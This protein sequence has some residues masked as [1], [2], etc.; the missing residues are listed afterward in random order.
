MFIIDSNVCFIQIDNVVPSNILSAME[1]VDYDKSCA[2]YTFTTS[3]MK[4]FNTCVACVTDISCMFHII[5][6]AH[7]F[8][9]NY[10][11]SIPIYSVIRKYISSLK[12]NLW[13]S[14][15]SVEDSRMR[16]YMNR[17]FPY[18]DIN[19]AEWKKANIDS[20]ANTYT[21]RAPTQVAN[22]E[23]DSDEDAQPTMQEK[24]AVT[25]VQ[26]KPVDDVNSHINNMKLLMKLECHEDATTYALLLA[27]NPLYIHVVKHPDFYSIVNA[28]TIEQREVLR[29]V[30]WYNSYIFSHEQMSHATHTIDN[31]CMYTHNEALAQ[32]FHIGTL[33]TNPYQVALT[34]ETYIT[35]CTPF[36][37]DGTRRL[38][39]VNVFNER[40]A[41]VTNKLFKNLDF[42]SL[43]AVISG[44]ILLP[45]THYSPLEKNFSSFEEYVEYYYPSYKSLNDVD[46]ASA[47]CESETEDKSCLTRIG[48]NQLSDIDLSVHTKN[49]TQFDEVFT[50]ILNTIRI[51][52]TG[53][54][55][56]KRVI[57]AASY[58]YKIYGPGVPRPIDVFRVT[59][60]PTEMVMRFHL[61]C[62]RMFYDGVLHISHACM[63][64]M[65]TGVN[66]SYKWF[67]CTTV[68]ADTVLKYCQRGMTTIL[69]KKER[70]A[71]TLYLKNQT[72]W[73]SVVVYG[74]VTN[75]HK[76][77]SVNGVREGLIDITLHVPYNNTI[78][79]A[80]TVIIPSHT[81]NTV[82]P[83][84]YDKIMG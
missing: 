34:N 55:Y 21:P 58:K 50:K 11:M 81:T 68:P 10:T 72:R 80:S 74:T 49:T 35:S 29:Y 44:S 46:Y 12:S 30:L 37:I 51:N 59:D 66:D 60:T 64:A 52:S 47:T 63:R 20:R 17:A 8:F 13:N 15:C 16:L 70:E 48:Y 71:L 76:F 56:S 4:F 83:P 3:D 14:I 25:W 36:Y 23:H 41:F 5:E 2:N 26:P 78:L 18:F 31:R 69:S 28:T 24:P 73:L 84:D 67:S 62:V 65:L 7:D 42:N 53:H 38:T 82:I 77:F 39:P 22:E 75:L 27:C 43:G 40:F 32:P 57:T 19:S 45:C 33:E 6:A 1:S 9:P 79:P 61:P 54:V